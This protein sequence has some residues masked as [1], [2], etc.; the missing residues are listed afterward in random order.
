[1]PASTASTFSERQRSASMRCPRFCPCRAPSWR[2]RPTRRLSRLR[3]ASAAIS[4]S[5]RPADASAC[6]PAQAARAGAAAAALL[7]IPRPSR[8]CIL[9]CDQMCGRAAA[10]LQV[11]PLRPARA[12]TDE[13]G[14]RELCAA[15]ALASKTCQ[16]RQVR[17]LAW[18][19]E[20]PSACKPT[21][22]AA[23]GL[24]RATDGAGGRLCPGC[25]SGRC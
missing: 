3:A 22:Q 2:S 4:G 15:A 16:G 24:T 17:A 13:S 14:C 25:H 11:P 6:M 7:S 8:P 12:S 9:S 1:M 5:C 18:L 10:A 23:Y 20:G 21:W 19:C